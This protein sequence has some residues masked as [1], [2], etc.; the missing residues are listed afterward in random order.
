[1]QVDFIDHS[2]DAKLQEDEELKKSVMN[3]D[4]TQNEQIAQPYKSKKLRY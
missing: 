1:M 3:Y 4:V 2:L